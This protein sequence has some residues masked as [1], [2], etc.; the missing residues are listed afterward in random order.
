MSSNPAAT[1]ARWIAEPARPRWPAM[2]TLASRSRGCGSTTAADFRE[3]QLAVGVDHQPR[4]IRREHL[5][6]PAQHFPGLGRVPDQRID[7][8]GAQVAIVELD[9][10]LPVQPGVVESELDEVPHRVG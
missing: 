4:Q 3:R 8:R 10:A 7:L 9:V 6:L 1:N 2:Y 5:G